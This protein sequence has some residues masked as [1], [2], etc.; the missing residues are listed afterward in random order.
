[1][2]RRLTLWIDQDLI[3]RAKAYSKVAGKSVSQLV[4]DYLALLPQRP[5][6]KPGR[7]TPNVQSLR[8]LMR[9]ASGDEQGYRRHLR[10]NTSDGN[11]AAVSSS[12]DRGAGPG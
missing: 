6:G 8:G 9:G 10:K 3:E 2:H 1:M 12:C 11:V 7:L 5:T 4:A